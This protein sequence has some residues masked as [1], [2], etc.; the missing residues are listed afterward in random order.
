MGGMIM[1]SNSKDKVDLL[2]KS[3]E[4]VKSLQLKN[5]GILATPKDAAYPYIYTRDSVIISKAMN[6]IGMADASEKFYYFMKKAVKIENYKEVFQRYTSSG[7]PSVTRK[8]QN[9][10][11]GLLLH[12]IY[13][14][15]LYNKKETF[16]ENMWM[17]VEQIVGLIFSYSRS[18]L[19]KTNSS[20]HEFKK[21]EKGYDLWVNCACYRGLKDAVKIAEILNH[22]KE[23]KEWDKKAEKIK[24]NIKKRLF[25]KKLKVYIKNRRFP[26]SPDISQLAPFY[27]DVV[28]DKKI[29]RNTL[30]Y[31]RKHIWDGEIGGFRRF[32]KFEVCD[33]WHWYT[34]GSGSWCVL[35]AMVARFYKKLNNKTG[36]NEC[37]KWLRDVAFFSDGFLP[38]HIATKEEYDDWKVHEIEFNSRIINEMNKAE[39]SVKNFKGKKMV[40]WANPLGWSHA[41]YILLRKGDLK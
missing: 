31:L 16:L 17:T 38:E 40:C 39:E 5:G 13:D 8:V 3:E 28:D 29:L 34:G 11:E 33:D 19:V 10:N 35:T 23:S 20:I 27:F 4:V 18:G 14:T 37:V 2:K 32:R 7:L 12:G 24:K 25:N 9:D 6:R 1:V 41:E 26:D 15:Y 36:Y 22:K 21:L 30:T